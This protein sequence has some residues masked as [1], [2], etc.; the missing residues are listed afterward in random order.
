MALHKTRLS[1]RLHFVFEHLIPNQDVWDFCCDHGYLGGTAYK[2]KQFKNIY[3]VDQVPH[4][5]E[6]IKIKFND[7]LFEEENTSKAFFITESGEN[8]LENVEG[9][10]SITG[11]GGQTIQNILSSLSKN[12]RL[13]AQRLILGPHKDARE[14]LEFI[15]NHPDLKKYC[16]Q[17]KNEILENG[18]TRSLFIYDFD[19]SKNLEAT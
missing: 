13:K 4:L 9:T 10:I 2:S 17:S 3:F 15:L 11:V 7:Y 19:T 18:R 1:D 14:M 5:I 12:N 6:K 16:L 8:I